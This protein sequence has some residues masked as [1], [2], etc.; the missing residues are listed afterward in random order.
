MHLSRQTA[1]RARSIVIFVAIYLFGVALSEH[2]YGSL[3]IPSPFWLPDSILLCAL[4]MTPA[5]D[6]WI[7][8]VAIWPVR[9]LVGSVPGTPLWFQ[10]A[11]IA[12]DALKAMVAAWLLDRLV[13]RRVRLQT[14]REFFVFLGVAALAVPLLSAAAAAPARYALGDPVWS[15]GY[16]WFLGNALA[17]VVVTPTI[18]YWVHGAYRHRS[19]RL[20]ELLIALTGL[21]VASLYAFAMMNT[22]YTLR[23]IYVPV[24][25]LLW[26]AVRLRP[27]GTA[28]AIALV[29]VIAMVGAARGTGIFSGEAGSSSILSLQLFLLVVGV[30]LMSLAILTAERE[31]LAEFG[32]EANSRILSAQEQER[33]RIARELHDD[34][35]QDLAVLHVRLEQ[36][37]SS[38]G[39]SSTAHREVNELVE[40]S[41]RIGSAVRKL[42][43]ELHPATLALL[44]LDVAVKSLCTE[45]ERQHHLPIH[46]SSRE[47]PGE[48]EG[49]TSV[50]AFRIAQEAL[51]NVVK[52]SRATT[53]AVHLS[54]EDGR[55]VLTVADDGDGF[56]VNAADARAG[57]GLISMRERLHLIGG[58]LSIRSTPRAGTRIRVEVPIARASAPFDTAAAIGGSQRVSPLTKSYR[59][60][61]AR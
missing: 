34:L 17:Q 55:L 3:A 52:H 7:F 10:L 26:A 20:G 59:T 6:R 37:G 23:L 2:A 22:G 13:G 12:N 49:E 14:L 29:A 44:G 46:Y 54:H 19:A 11:T 47:V 36:F 9:L 18:L 35:A 24:P 4:L 21:M 60:V 32:R 38:A 15:A 28:N 51:R 53:A 40:L 1:A 33:S 50:C 30:S 48:L 58:Q 57:L 42:S 43:H 56:D 25:F 39:L 8:V 31:T 61:K 5:Q 16:R 27:F 45:V 41:S